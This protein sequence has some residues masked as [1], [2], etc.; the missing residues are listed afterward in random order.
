MLAAEERGVS[1]PSSVEPDHS[2]TRGQMARLAAAFVA[3]NDGELDAYR[4]AERGQFESVP[5]SSSSSSSR[6]SPSSSSRD[7]LLL[8][9]FQIFE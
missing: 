2:L 5:S 7:R 8:I 4:A 9:L 1:L 3:E 6:S